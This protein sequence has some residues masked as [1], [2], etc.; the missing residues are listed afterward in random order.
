MLCIR[1]PALGYTVE[2]SGYRNLGMEAR[3]HEHKRDGHHTTPHTTGAYATHTT[4]SFIL[5]HKQNYNT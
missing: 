1:Y 2:D 5:F 4:V 3:H